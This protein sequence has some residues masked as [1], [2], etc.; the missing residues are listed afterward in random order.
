MLLRIRIP[1]ALPDPATQCPW[2]LKD[3]VG[4][5]LSAGEDRPEALPDATELELIA[6][7]SRVLLTQI[8]LPRRSRQ[9]L[10]EM[11]PFAI[12]DRIS[13][14]PDRV[15]VALGPA[16]ADGTYAVAVVDREWLTRWIAAF[17]QAARTPQSLR[18]ETCLAPLEPHAWVVVWGGAHGFVRTG[19]AGGFALDAGIAPSPPI[20]LRL[21]LHEALGKSNAPDKLVMRA[22]VDAAPDLEAWSAELGVPCERAEAWDW[23]LAPQAQGSAAELNLLQGEFA[24]PSATRDLMP[25]L[26]PAL[27]L[28]ALIAG[29]HVIG[30]LVHWGILQH[31]RTQLQAE[32]KAIFRNSFPAAQAIVD[33]PLQ[34]RRQLDSARRAAGQGQPGDFLPLLAQVASGYEGVGG[35]RLKNISYEQGRLLV[36]ID[37]GSRAEAEVLLRR[38]REGGATVALEAV[39]SRGNRVEARFAASVRRGA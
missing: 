22:P 28:C 17:T 32:M 6:P 30:T 37:L 13:V 14:E 7:A 38:L 1:E 33:P 11:L 5:I 25:G 34:M 20:V 18:V 21:A 4:R 35:A 16:M 27:V 24:P 3:A 39:N 12:E 31:E 23:T 8:A 15:H 10:R 19:P 9:R 36:D 26:R 29:L 2:V